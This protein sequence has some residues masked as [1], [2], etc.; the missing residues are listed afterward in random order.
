MWIRIS[1]PL[2]KLFSKLIIIIRICTSL[3]HICYSRI[4]W[5][6]DWP[7]RLDNWLSPSL[8]PKYLAKQSCKNNL[9]LW[10][11]RKH[12][13]FG[14]KLLN[15]SFPWANWWNFFSRKKSSIFRFWVWDLS[16]PGWWVL[17]CPR[18][19]CWIKPSKRFSSGLYTIRNIKTLI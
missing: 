8:S 9:V 3:Y 12:W 18:I 11:S 19:S 10:F 14:C 7:K 17:T 13:V 6:K 15:I 16:H 2:F 1:K 5:D 4:Q